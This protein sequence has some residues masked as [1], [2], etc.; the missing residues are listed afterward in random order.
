MERAN[1][2]PGLLAIANRRAP[3]VAVAIARRGDPT[4]LSVFEAVLPKVG[5]GMLWRSEFPIDGHVQVQMV[6]QR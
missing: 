6:R 4:P 2:R 5:D 3:T 1:G